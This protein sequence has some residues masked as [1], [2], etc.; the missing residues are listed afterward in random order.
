MIPERY[1]NEAT[2]QRDLTRPLRAFWIG[3]TDILAA[4]DPAQALRLAN[5]P[6]PDVAYC[7]DDVS[8]VDAATLDERLAD[9]DGKL[10]W[11]LRGL[12]QAQ[13]EAGYLAGFEG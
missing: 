3:D 13:T 6:G 7:L 11:T 5:G 4:A 10:A 2:E 9:A 8:E 1:R 12:L